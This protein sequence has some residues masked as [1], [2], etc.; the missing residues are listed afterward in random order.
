MNSLNSNPPFS[1]KDYFILFIILCSLGFFKIAFVSPGIKNALELLALAMI[2]SSVILLSFYDSSFSFKKRYRVIIYIM[3]FSVFLSMFAAYFFHKQGFVTTLV[4]QRSVY[5]ILFYFLLHKLKIH[6]NTLL[7]IFIFMALAHIVL[8][9]A[10]TAIYPAKILDTKMSVD[11]GTVRIALP[12]GGYIFM[13]YFLA[14]SLYFITK[15]YKYLVLYIATI[16]I[17]VLWGARQSISSLALM[18]M[19]YI[20]LSKR[21]KSK[22]LIYTLVLLSVIPFYFLFKDIFDSMFQVTKSQ[23][24]DVD[25]NMRL[26]SAT[27]YL[28]DFIPNKICYLIGNG[29]ASLNSEYGQRLAYIQYSLGY[30]RED[31]GLIGSWSKYGLLFALGELAIWIK[32]AAKKLPEKYSFI[33]YNAIAGLLIIFGGAGPFNEPDG[34]IVMCSMLYLQDV[35]LTFQD[36]KYELQADLHPDTHS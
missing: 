24:E 16:S 35:V 23:S 2:L 4:V 3:F 5:F 36:P 13:V 15:K 6:P 27:Y 11:R 28:T 26:L 7:K 9:A 32:L 14:L 10:Q 20:L 34:A 30:W 17:V 21:I 8:Y 25:S 19:V 33:R 1:L 31:I 12:G 29:V 18:T 22:F